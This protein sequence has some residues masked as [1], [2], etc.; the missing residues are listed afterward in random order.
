MTLQQ[1]LVCD[2][3]ND[4]DDEYDDKEDGDDYEEE[5]GDDI[6]NAFEDIVTGNNFH[7]L[8]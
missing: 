1:I 5:D 8:R 7:V 2:D 6:G 4:N 3:Y